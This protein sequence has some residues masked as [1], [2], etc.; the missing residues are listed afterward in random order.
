MKIQRKYNIIL[1][2]LLII[3]TLIFLCQKMSVKEGAIIDDVK[4]FTRYLETLRELK[5]KAM[6]AAGVS[7]PGPG[8]VT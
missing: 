8:D 5:S 7:M 4:T 2:F 1:I 6:N 3:V